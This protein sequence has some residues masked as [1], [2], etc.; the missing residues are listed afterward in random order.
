MRFDNKFFRNSI[1]I[2]DKTSLDLMIAESMSIKNLND[3]FRYMEN[4]DDLSNVSIWSLYFCIKES[5]SSDLEL[6]LPKMSARQRVLLRDIGTW[7]ADEL[8]L[9]AFDQW[10]LT[11]LKLEDKEIIKEFV[12]SSDFLLYLK[13]RC[14]VYYFDEED[15]N[16]PNHDF[17]FKTDDDQFIFEFQDGFELVDEMKT[18]VKHFYAAFGVDHAREILI[19]LIPESFLSLQENHYNEKKERLRDIGYVDYYEAIILQAYHNSSSLKDFIKKKTASAYQLSADLYN[20]FNNETSSHHHQVMASFLGKT[21][22]INNELNILDDIQRE[23]FL[24]F[25]LSRLI[26]SLLT[27]SKNQESDSQDPY[28]KVGSEAVGMVNIALSYL[29]SLFIKD[30]SISCFSFFDFIDL[31]RI[32]ASLLHLE[33]MKIARFTKELDFELSFLGDHF[34]GIIDEINDPDFSETFTQKKRISDYQELEKIIKEV[35]LLVSLKGVFKSYFSFKMKLKLEDG[36]NYTH[37]DLD[38]ET[39]FLTHFSLITMKKESSD[40]MNIEFNDF[41]VFFEMWTNDEDLEDKVQSFISL[42]KLDTYNNL[43]R[44]LISILSENLSTLVDQDL[45]ELKP[46]YISG[47]L[48]KK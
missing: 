39:L 1:M 3:L 5:T 35:N 24:N 17:F 19:R 7:R 15:V 36:F 14:Q 11:F 10:C 48:I 12:S 25:N 13:G 20:D 26:N 9:K 21:D 47:F 42:N 2:K 40:L 44:Y 38:F 8:N 30:S 46:E 41:I 6:V 34:N 27:L 16:Y 4:K 22:Y 29:R 32:G 45:S 33:K 18:L 37:D 23:I 31:Y 43:D 28:S